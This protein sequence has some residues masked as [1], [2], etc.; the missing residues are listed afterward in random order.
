MD[1]TAAP[2]LAFL[3]QDPSSAESSRVVGASEW[4]LEM[5]NTGGGWAAFYTN[6][7]KLFLNRNPFSDM[8]SL[9]Y[10]SSADVTERILETFG[11]FISSVCKVYLA[12]RLITRLKLASERAIINLA[13][14]QESYSAWY[15]Q[16]GSITFMARATCC[17]VKR[18]F[19][20][21]IAVYNAWHV[22]RSTGSSRFRMMMSAEKQY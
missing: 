6:N 2:I 10:P 4:I 3:K 13:R 7:N 17:A 20:V 14:S 21:M 8:D 22:Q 11:L 12:G 19:Q 15:G 9:W 1:N 16:W 5:Q 18:V